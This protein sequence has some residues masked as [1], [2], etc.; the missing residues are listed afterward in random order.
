MSFLARTG[1]VI[2]DDSF[3]YTIILTSNSYVM[4]TEIVTWDGCVNDIRIVTC[5]FENKTGTLNTGCCYQ[6]LIVTSDGVLFDGC[7]FR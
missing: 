6:E 5:L 2:Q 7:V 1:N 4:I 3:I